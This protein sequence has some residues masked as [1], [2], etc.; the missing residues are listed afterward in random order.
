MMTQTKKTLFSETYFGASALDR[1]SGKKLI[2]FKSVF[3]KI[4][5]TKSAFARGCN[6]TNRRISS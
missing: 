1:L 6:V 2:A 5:Q 4:V 3:V